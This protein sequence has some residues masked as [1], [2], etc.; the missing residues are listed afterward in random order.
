MMTKLSKI[1]VCLP[2]SKLMQT[3]RVQESNQ[4]N[5]MKNKLLLLTSESHSW[6]SRWTCFV[7]RILT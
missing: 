2:Q 5:S 4:H 7:K 6:N 3:R 1:P